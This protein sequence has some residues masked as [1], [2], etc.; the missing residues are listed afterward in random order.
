MVT[1]AAA[2]AAEGSAVVFTVTLPDP[3]P[4][5]GMTVDYSTSDGRGNN[6]DASH[7]IATSADYTAANA[8]L[9]IAAGA[10]SGTVS[11]PTTDDSTYEGDH[12][13]TLTLTNPSD[14][15]LSTLAGSAVGTITDAADRPSFAFSAA[16]TSADEDDGTLTLTVEKT[17]TTLV[18]ATVSYATTDGTATGG[19]DF[20]AI[21]STEL[22]FA[23]AD[24]S[25]DITVSLTDDSSDEPTEAFTVD[26]TAGAHAALGSTSSHS[27][28]ITDNDA[29]RVAT[30]TLTPASIDEDGGASRGQST[31]TANLDGTT[32][33]DVTLTVAAAPVLPAVAGDYTLSANR[34]LTI[35]AGATA[36][37]GV[38]TLTAVDNSLDAPNKTVTVSATASGGNGVANPADVA[39]T[40]TDDEAPPAV[41]VADASAVVEGD[42]PMTTR[43]MSFAL[44]LSEI[45]GQTV[46]VPYTLTGS[47]TGGSDYESPNP[48]SATIAAG[49]KSG[50]IVVRVKGDTAD[51]LDETIDLRLG[52][53]IN[54]T[55]ST[56]AG[57]GTASGTITDDDPT[58][59]TLA[60][61][62][63]GG[64]A[65]DGGTAEVTITLGRT[66]V[67][68]ES[69][70][71]PLTVTG[72]TVATHYTLG[73]KDN[74]GT[75]VSLDTT[76]PHS[77]Q[78]PQVTLAGAGARTATLTLTAIANTD[79]T[80]RT[81]AIAFGTDTRAPSSTGLDGGI[82]TTGSA[83]VPIIDDDSMVTVAAASAAEGSAV[84]FTVT[85]PDP[86]PSG[87]VTV[88]YSTSDGRGNN[89]DA[90][91][92]VATSADYT[93]A[94]AT[95]SIAAGARSGTVSISTTDDSTYEGD[96]YFTLTLAN[97]NPSRFTLSTLAGS[98]VGTITDAAD[99]PSFAFSAAST[100]ADE[101]DGTL[102]LTV[103]KTGTTLVAATVSYATTDGT[104]T[105]G[106][107]FT[108]IA[109][110]ELD[111]AVADT[112]KDITVSLTDDSSDEP[113]EAFTV[114]LTAGA[115]AAL[116]ST[117]RHSITITDNDATTV[118]LAAPSTAIGE[119]AGS[120]TLTVTLGRALTGDETLAVP[121]TLRRHRLP[122]AWTTRWPRRARP[123][124]ASPIRTSP[125]PT[126]P[127][128]R[129]R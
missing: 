3:A 96:H 113:T 52:T 35:A 97:P 24:T 77:A 32:S 23:V 94:N 98:A 80:S 75:G 27:I 83:S 65:E 69:V 1:V 111:F 39:L 109:S 125:V 89:D 48:L 78:D 105:G 19:S 15:N 60:R 31:V 29:T 55:V 106:S 59:V 20:T 85:L 2:S 58:V 120:K 81:V 26:L 7:Q 100:A 99:R 56:E 128:V 41:S 119:N 6:A 74:G 11:I 104:A 45:S 67:A 49:Q 107:D 37:T 50:A 18:A 124:P 16:S 5:G 93:A 12:H 91:H 127:P 51:E 126:S 129:R 34:T 63:S 54:A 68:G 117:T 25:K 116:G 79:R 103:E 102:T 28:T 47:A 42:D 44:A 95:L 115:H 43:E 122:S 64:I 53:P 82:T 14:F 33:Q 61:T 21:A 10:E 90:S 30:L 17:G 114:D 38:V 121:L 101:D 108:A 73:L 123:P 88:D 40:I 70:T 112:S 72:P 62:G 13:F 118:T 66:L 4:V 71:V 36:S 22:D 84:V 87:G 8:T 92:Q 76:S 57:A 9:S 110:T 46:T 86:A